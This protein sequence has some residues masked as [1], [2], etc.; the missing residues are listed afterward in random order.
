M[1][2]PVPP[3]ALLIILPC[4]VPELIVPIDDRYADAIDK[5]FSVSLLKSE[6]NTY[7]I[8]DDENNSTTVNIINNDIAGIVKRVI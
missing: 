8:K 2:R 3:Y 4:H 6:D 7:E 5:S 1:L